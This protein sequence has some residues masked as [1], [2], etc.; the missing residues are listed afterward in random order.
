MSLQIERYLR[1]D[2]H[3][4]FIAYFQTFSNTY[5]SLERLKTMYDTV[6][7]FSDIVG[8]AIG[9]R[10]DCV[11]EEILNLIETYTDTYEVWIE[12]GLQSSHNKTLEKINRGHTCQQFLEAVEL[13]SSRPIR[14]CVHVILGLPGENHEDVLQT[15]RLISQLPI[16]GIKFHPLQII[17]NTPMESMYRNGEI[18]LLDGET[19]ARWVVDFLEILPPGMV[20][21]RI[22]AD[23]PDIW[24]IAPDWCRNKMNVINRVDHIFNSRNSR[25]GK[26]YIIK[27][28]HHAENI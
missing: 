27:N 11:N 26:K 6:R 2:R 21:Q 3:Q 19:Y 13:T 7:E 17:R 5:A 28:G 25:Q 15:A 23:A 14:I 22:T 24:L 10:P 9:T 8:I 20:V 12:Y 16:H 4:K 18:Q 1:K